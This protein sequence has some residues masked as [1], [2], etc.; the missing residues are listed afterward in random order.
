M[1]KTHT[2]TAEL[3]HNLPMSLAVDQCGDI[4]MSWP[5][6]NFASASFLA[7]TF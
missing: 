7:T 4:F 2:R 5:C 1:K 3:T 6:L